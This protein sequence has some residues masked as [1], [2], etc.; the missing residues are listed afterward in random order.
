MPAKQATETVTGQYRSISYW[1]ISYWSTSYWSTSY[2]SKRR[3]RALS[4]RDRLG[5]RRRPAAAGGGQ[6][7]DPGNA[8]GPLVKKMLGL[9]VQKKV[10]L[11]LS[12]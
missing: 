11:G 8:F 5:N 4:A 10:V 6:C 3:S 7:T 12:V 1:S 2:W 9:C